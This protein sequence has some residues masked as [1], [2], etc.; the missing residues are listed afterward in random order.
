MTGRAY[1]LFQIAQ[2]VLVKPERYAV[3]LGVKKNADGTVKQPLFACALDDTPWLS[4]A[5]AIA[6]VL[7][8]HFATFYQAERTSI[9]PPK[10][11]YTFVA[12]CGMSGKILGPPNHHD[13]QNQLRKLFL[14]DSGA[15]QFGSVPG[16]SWR[17][18][19]VDDQL[20]PSGSRRFITL[21]GSIEKRIGE[22]NVGALEQQAVQVF[23][24]DQ[25]ML[26]FGFLSHYLATIDFPQRKIFLQ[27]RQIGRKSND[28]AA[29]GQRTRDRR[30]HRCRTSCF[31]TPA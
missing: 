2:I 20:T 6:H 1:P 15:S 8:V 9:E 18:L 14:L 28:I 11:K 4:E 19:M 17:R 5:E 16:E 22:I 30:S 10:G 24:G 13:Y 25:A 26:G 21:G 31:S 3:Q 23:E 7:K 29:P 27:D 12:Q